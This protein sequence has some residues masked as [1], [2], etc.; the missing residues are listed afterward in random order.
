MHWRTPNP[1]ELYTVSCAT[2]HMYT[3]CTLFRRNNVTFPHAN[4]STCLHGGG[5]G[6]FR[7]R[8]PSPGPTGMGGVPRRYVS[9]RAGTSVSRVDSHRSESRDCRD[10][11][12]MAPQDPAFPCSR[13]G[14][15]GVAR[16]CAKCNHRIARRPGRTRR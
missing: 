15:F 14:S 10:K 13:V 4:A 7:Q 11:V 16:T 6:P 2:A 12:I 3:E 9:R 8:S 5:T 1:V